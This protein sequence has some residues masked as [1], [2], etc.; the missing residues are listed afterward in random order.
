MTIKTAI[1]RLNIKTHGSRYD[2]RPG[3]TRTFLW[4]TAVPRA[5]AEA[6]AGLPIDFGG[7]MVRAG[8]YTV[9]LDELIGA[10]NDY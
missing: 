4:S 6:R 7:C 1:L 3:F 5:V 10:E 8:D 9:I 2:E